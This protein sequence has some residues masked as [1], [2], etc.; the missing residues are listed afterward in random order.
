MSKQM[1]PVDDRATSKPEVIRNTRISASIQEGVELSAKVHEFLGEKRKMLLDGKWADAL[2]GRTFATHNPATG[3]VLA[4]VAEADAADVDRAVDAAERARRGSWA[5]WSSADRAKM[6]WRLADLIE[7]N[8]EE[9]ATLEALNNGQPFSVARYGFVPFAVD[10][11][12]YAAGLARGLHGET[13]P[14]TAPLQP[15]KRFFAYT[16]REPIGVVGQIIPWNVPILMVAWKLAP[17]LAA[18]CTVILKPAEQTPLTALYIGKLAMEA[19]LPDGVLNI[20]PGFGETAGAAIAAHPRIDKIA[21]TGSGEVGKL[22]VKAAADNLKRVT[23][24]LGGKS[25]NIVMEDADI[26][27]AAEN[28]AAGVFFNSGQAC[29][30]PSRLY[31]H[32]KHFDRI[33]EA[34]IT[35]ARQTCLGHAF[36]PNATMGPLVSNEQLNR[37]CSYVEHSAREGAKTVFGGRRHSDSGYFFEPT[38]IVQTNRSHRI[39]REEVFG[40]VVAATPFNSLEDVIEQANDTTYGL[41]AGVWTR[42]VQKAHRVAHALKAGTV[43]INTYHAFDNALPFGGYRQSGWGRELGRTA[44]DAYMETKSVVTAL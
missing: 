19:G 43:W 1:D 38:V 25:P 16:V 21:F 41:A 28:A 10:T 8:A 39:M 35:A 11:F 5:M 9:L 42:D 17:A 34:V 30:A 44:L 27:A 3:G 6:L 31:V 4:Q 32:S 26:A 12:R 20:V 13:V 29:T 33:V 23:L 15:G 40:P 22:I 7:E 2:S 36:D 18:G 37:V 24:E 14:I